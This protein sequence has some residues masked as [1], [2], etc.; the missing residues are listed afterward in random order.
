MER[1]LRY[2]GVV[3]DYLVW[4]LFGFGILATLF[5]E[6][7][8]LFSQDSDVLL[9]PLTAFALGAVLET[10]NRSF[11]RSS[12][13]ALV[14]GLALCRFIGLVALAAA[15]IFS[16]PT[17][18]YATDVSNRSMALTLIIGSVLGVLEIVIRRND[19][20]FDYRRVS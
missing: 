20:S 8:W 16:I 4:A 14:D 5:C 13:W 6:G 19:R 10:A 1:C 7:Y 15:L 3:L 9:I 18:P 11:I 2:T 12:F 17:S